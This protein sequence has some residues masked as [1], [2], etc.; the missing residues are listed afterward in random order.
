MRP[1]DTSHRVITVLNADD[2]AA[3]GLTLSDFTV[4]ARAR[5][6]GASV[7]STY[8]HSAALVELGGGDYALAFLA[9]PSAGWFILTIRPNVTTRTVWN[10]RWEG[11]VEAQDLDSVYTGLSSVQLGQVR[12]VR[13]GFTWPGELIAYRWNQ[14]EIPIVDQNGDPVDLSGYTNLSLS[15]RTANQTTKKLDA[16]NGSPTGF[17]LT[18]SAGGLLTVTWPE[19]LGTVGS[20][21]DIYSIVPTGQLV[22]SEALYME[23][24]G[25]VAG[26]ATKTVPLVRSSPL[27]IGR[28]EVGT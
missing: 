18:G 6:F 19:S 10:Q 3:T 4:T 27:V 9:P 23:I 17:G 13:L 5:G 11:E 21:A 16:T 12:N 20:A 22:M 26:D 15:V 8:T 1:G 2:S 14:W 7:W 25:D 28:R 24:T